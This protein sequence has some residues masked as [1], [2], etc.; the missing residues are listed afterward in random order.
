[1][2][3]LTVGIQKG[4]TGKTTT[5][6]SL[7]GVLSKRGKTLLVDCDP[8]GNAT[9]WLVGNVQTELVQVLSGLKPLE[10]AILPTKQEGLFVLPTAALGGKPKLADYTRLTDQMDQIDTFYSIIR[11]AEECGYCY[12]VN[13]LGPHFGPLEQGAYLSADDII[14]V[15]NPELLAVSGLEIFTTN[16]LHIKDV[17]KRSGYKLG[18]YNKIVI[19]MVNRSIKQHREVVESFPRDNPEFQFFIVPQEPA[20]RQAL[21]NHEVVL[22]NCSA[23]PETLKA[24]TALADAIEEV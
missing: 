15:I 22:S 18:E 6:V 20:F 8:Q 21:V 4:G 14:S 2:K 7:A 19:N 9:E 12:V 1:M 5:A 17:F 10:E 16:L 3:T 24:F 11:R 23:K 13:D